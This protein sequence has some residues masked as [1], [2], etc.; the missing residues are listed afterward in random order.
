MPE[1]H[2]REQEYRFKQQIIELI[3]DKIIGGGIKDARTCS[4]TLPRVIA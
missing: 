2:L 4:S 3:E 1:R